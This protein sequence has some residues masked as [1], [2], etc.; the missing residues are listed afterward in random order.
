MH[1]VNLYQPERR[2]GLLRPSPLIA[3]GL[4]GL[5]VVAVLLDG[6]WLL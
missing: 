5:L 6:A 1:N 4:L 3:L 2:S